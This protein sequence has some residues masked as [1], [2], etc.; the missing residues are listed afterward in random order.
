ML[1][2]E[3]IIL[4]LD[5]LIIKMVAI[6]SLDVAKDALIYLSKPPVWKK[7]SELLLS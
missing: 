5:T 1:S 7:K 4:W 6:R 2:S 3:F